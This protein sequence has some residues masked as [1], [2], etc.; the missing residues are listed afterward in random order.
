MIFS[1]LVFKRLAASPICGVKIQL[2]FLNGSLDSK[3]R[4]PASTTIFLSNSLLRIKSLNN[5]N[6]FV[7][8][9]SLAVPGPSSKF[10]YDPSFF[11]NPSKADDEINSG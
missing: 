3:L 9:L 5:E 1:L 7:D 2:S 10:L 8:H 6:I 11:S 4:N